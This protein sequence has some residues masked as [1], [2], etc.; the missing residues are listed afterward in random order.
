[1]RR[2]IGFTLVRAAPPPRCQC[3]GPTAV[4]TASSLA[5]IPF[6]YLLSPSFSLHIPRWTQNASSRRPCSFRSFLPFCFLSYV[7]PPLSLKVPGPSEFGPTALLRRNNK[8]LPFFLSVQRRSVPPMTV[9]IQ[10]PTI[11]L[12][13]V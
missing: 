4:Y 2:Q 7:H 10:T 8:M 13:T 5:H 1:M 3:E 11:R 9:S 12:P 6:L